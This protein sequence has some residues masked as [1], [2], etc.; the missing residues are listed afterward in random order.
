MSSIS[1]AQI[2]DEDAVVNPITNVTFTESEEY[3]YQ[4]GTAQ[5]P[6]EHKNLPDAPGQINV[7]REVEVQIDR[8]SRADLGREEESMESRDRDPGNYYLTHQGQAKKSID[9]ERKSIG[10]RQQRGSFGFGCGRK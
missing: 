8:Q 7:K 5:T 10:S 9:T 2:T 3:I 6:P 4:T 1:D